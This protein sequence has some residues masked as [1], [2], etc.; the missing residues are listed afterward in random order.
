M[1]TSLF[2]TNKLM[3]VICEHGKNFKVAMH[4]EVGEK[5]L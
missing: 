3:K 2:D 1:K 4:S 5:V